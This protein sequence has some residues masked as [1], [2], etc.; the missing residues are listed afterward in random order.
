MATK[1]RTITLSIRYVSFLL[2]VTFAIIACLATLL[3]LQLTPTTV[4]IVISAPFDASRDWGYLSAYSDN[5]DDLFG[6]EYVGLPSGCR[7]EQVHV[8]QRSAQRLPLDFFEEGSNDARFAQKLTQ[9]QSQA[10]DSSFSGSLAFLNDYRYTLQDSGALTRVGAATELQRGA[11]VW[12]WY[13]A[14]LY[15]QN[16][17][18]A[19]P[20][21]MPFARS[22]GSKHV[23][24]SVPYW[25]A[26][27]QGVSEDADNALNIS[28]IMSGFDYLVIPEGESQNNTLASYDTCANAD[29]APIYELGDLILEKYIPI[30]LQDG[31][32]RLQALAP[33]EFAL[34]TT[35]LYAM[36]SI[37]AFETNA[38]GASPF[39]SLFTPDEWNGFAYTFDQGSYYDIS[40]GNPTGRAQG[41]GFLQELLARLRGQYID[42]SDSSVN[43]TIDDTPSDFPLGRKLYV[44]FTHDGTIL[45]LLTAMSIDYFKE[46]PELSNYPIS[47]TR[48]FNIAQISPSGANLITEVIGCEDSAPESVQDA[49]YWSKT[50]DTSAPLRQQGLYKFIRMRLNRGILPLATIRGGACAARP[51][52]LC[53]IDKFLESQANAYE[54]SNYDYACNGD[55]ADAIG[56]P[57]SGRDWDGTIHSADIKG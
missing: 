18:Q 42:E 51:D 2:L 53:V 41:I 40:F 31:L 39:C 54:M 19:D 27:F 6:V 21:T 49:N 28:A 57:T 16:A 1:R 45:S 47:A 4:K 50:T 14:D 29:R 30:Y 38:L 17:T 9:W 3:A 43:S 25:I 8:L 36:Q 55:Y 35:D 48:K 32:S 23:I 7:V 15:G 52:G 20:N 5:P 12:D 37:C 24:I 44:D 26:G 46:P 10:S 22:A 33:S 13:G 11:A 56:D 34:N